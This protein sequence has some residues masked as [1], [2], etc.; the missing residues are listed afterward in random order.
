MPRGLTYNRCD[1]IFERANQA[2]VLDQTPYE[3][4][5][6]RREDQKINRFLCL[7]YQCPKDVGSGA[8]YL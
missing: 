7:L 5:E 1:I 6:P 2:G 4:A 3:R 8:G